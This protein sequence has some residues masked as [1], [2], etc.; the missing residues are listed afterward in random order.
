[1][2]VVGDELKAAHQFVSP[3]KY[4][5]ACRRISRSVASLVRSARSAAT[6]ASRRATFC[7]GVS[8]PAG[9]RGPLLQPAPGRVVVVPSG[10]V[11]LPVPYRSTQW[12]KVPRTIPR[13]AAIPRSVAPG[14]DSYKSTACRRNSSE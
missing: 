2:A 13:S 10:A 14:V 3:A 6:S 8:G 5:A 4:F 9:G 11:T 7:S 12:L 1:V